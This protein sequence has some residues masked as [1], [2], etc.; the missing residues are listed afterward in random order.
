[1]TIIWGIVGMLVGVLIAAQLAWPVLNFDL[2]WLT[3]SRLRPLHTKRDL[4]I[5][6]LGLVRTSYMLQ[7]TCQRPVQRCAR[8]L[9]F[10][11]ATGHRVGAISFPLAHQSKEYAELNGDRHSDRV[12]WCHSIVFSA[13]SP[14]ARL[15]I[16]MWLTGSTGVHYHR[17]VLHIGNAW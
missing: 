1:V 11:L 4:R 17:R 2:P 12:V 6:R 10:W 16:S 5:R 14:S 7:R 8:E 3:F 13:R 9:Y 15:R